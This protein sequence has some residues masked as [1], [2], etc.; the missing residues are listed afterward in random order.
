MWASLVTAVETLLSAGGERDEMF[1]K[2]TVS[3]FFIRLPNLVLF[4]SGLY[5]LILVMAFFFGLFYGDLIQLLQT[6][7]WIV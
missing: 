5:M 2:I 1:E 3:S 6:V 7:I 4:T